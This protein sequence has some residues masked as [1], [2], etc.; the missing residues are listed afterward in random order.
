MVEF[1]PE[2]G[3]AL[4]DE[5]GGARMPISARLALG[6]LGGAYCQDLRIG[7]EVPSYLP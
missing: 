1:A 2:R 6:R 7:T 3:A 4:P 5:Q